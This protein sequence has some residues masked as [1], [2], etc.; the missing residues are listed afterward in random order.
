MTVTV[1]ALGARVKSDDGDAVVA[2]STSLYTPGACG[3]TRRRCSAD[4]D[5][6]VGCRHVAAAPALQGYVPAVNNSLEDAISNPDYITLKTSERHEFVASTSLDS[7]Q[8]CAVA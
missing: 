4:K 6:P 1:P 5:C 8:T 2:A 3:A 7:S